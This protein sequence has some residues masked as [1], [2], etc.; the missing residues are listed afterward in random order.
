MKIH[1]AEAL[2]DNSQIN[3]LNKSKEVQI[4]R[5]KHPAYQ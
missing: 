1:D 5:T 3:K 4:A 2:N